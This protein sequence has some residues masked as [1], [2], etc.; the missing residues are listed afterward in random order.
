[1]F[2]QNSQKEQNTREALCQNLRKLQAFVNAN[3]PF[4]PA[5]TLQE[6]QQRHAPQSATHV[7]STPSTPSTA[8]ANSQS[9]DRHGRLQYSYAQHR[10]RS[11]RAGSP[12]C[13]ISAATAEAPHSPVGFFVFDEKLY[14]T[15][16][17]RRRRRPHHRRRR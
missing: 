4:F 3:W 8:L 2:E 6:K 10:E 7:V 16:P 12:S 9:G 17:G 5:F 11:D 13:R 1:M 15:S 14:T